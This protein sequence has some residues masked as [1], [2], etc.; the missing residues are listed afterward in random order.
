MENL[1]TQREELF[2]AIK[3]SNVQQIRR[4]LAA[5]VSP[6]QYNAEGRTALMVAAQIGNPVVIQLLCTAVA[7]SPR[8]AQIF[9]ETTHRGSELVTL[10]SINSAL[11][12]TDSMPLDLGPLEY[13]PVPESVS[14]Q[15]V[16]SAMQP[17]SLTPDF[18]FSPDLKDMVSSAST[19]SPAA[20]SAPTLSS[21]ITLT[22]KTLTD[23]TPTDAYA[24]LKA[25]VCRNDIGVVKALIKA[26]TDLRPVTWHDTSVLMIAAQK[27]YTDVL[28]VLIT[29]GANVNT[30]YDRL[31]LHAAAEQG[32]LAVVQRLLNSGADIHSKEE[33]G[34]TA[35]M[36]AANH[37]HLP[38]VQML[39][40]RGA[41]ANA[42]SQGE[43]ALMLAAQNNHQAVC[44]FLGLYIPSQAPPSM[45]HTDLVSIVE[46]LI[47]AATV[48]RPISNST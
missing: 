43:T 21:P 36:L 24:S 14:P 16:T 8:P 40:S 46:R 10:D 3:V 31:P 45:G 47:S 37:G 19:P 1:T 33:S 5:N 35:L 6:N 27:G 39:V 30:G 29:A 32:H 28:Q 25:A 44:Q 20:S 2:V 7:N 23:K 41:D 12:P 4:L 18:G 34:R 22:D 13:S 17:K 9:F 48:H 38:I 26:G 42:V 11:L 15:P